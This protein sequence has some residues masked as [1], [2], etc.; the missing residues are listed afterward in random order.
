MTVLLYAVGFGLSFHSTCLAHHFLTFPMSR[1]FVW[2]MATFL[3]MEGKSGQSILVVHC[4]FSG[5]TGKNRGRKHWPSRSEIENDGRTPGIYT[6]KRSSMFHLL[7][8]C[9]EPLVFFKQSETFIGLCW[10]CITMEPSAI[11]AVKILALFKIRKSQFL[12]YTSLELPRSSQPEV[13]FTPA[14]V[15]FSFSQKFCGKINC[16][17][18]VYCCK[19][20]T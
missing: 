6:L 2:K 8:Y 1:L 11:T 17:T 9:W 13:Y 20:K 18:L 4:L 5:K 3:K 7:A 19:S 15:N 12:M 14:L 10:L 16:F